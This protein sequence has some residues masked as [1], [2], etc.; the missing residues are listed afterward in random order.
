[1]SFGEIAI[2][3]C[4][5][6]L[7]YWLVSMFI[8]NKPAPP[9]DR[10]PSPELQPAAAAAGAWHDVLDISAEASTEEIRAA[11]RQ[12]LSQYHPDKVASLGPELRELAKRKT[13]DIIDAY[14]V[15]MRQRGVE[16]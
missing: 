9:V 16:P 6:L 8:S 7:G 10:T 12:L 14:Q 15:G 13:Q 2:A 3:V 1:M 4:G 11:Y 5:L